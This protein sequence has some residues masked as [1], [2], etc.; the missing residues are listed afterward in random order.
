MKSIK[1]NQQDYF[2]KFQQGDEKGLEYFYKLLYPGL[3]YTGLRYIKDDIN[4]DCIVNEAFLRLWIIRQT[5]TDPLHLK[6]FLKKLTADSCKS[7]YKTS[8]SKFQRN[9]LRLEEIENYQEFMLGYDPDAENESSNLYQQELEIESSKQ[10]LQ[11]QSLL[12]NL[13]EQQQLFIRLCL[14]YGFNYERIAWHIGGISDYQVAKKVES[15]LTCLKSIL[16]DSQ[17]LHDVGKTSKFRFEGDLCEQQSSI[18]QMRY[19]L[20]YSFAE[21]ASALNLDQGY[22]QRVFA[23]ACTK[24][25]KVKI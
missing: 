22:I 13:S 10:W 17:Q 20:Q 12:P 19:E 9:M 21:I 25:R 5:I 1:I 18:L 14:K 8:G 2:K 15:T 16:A 7:Y 6:T 4:A 24:I 3:Y 11:V 23:S